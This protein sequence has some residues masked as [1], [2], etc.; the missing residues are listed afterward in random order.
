MWVSERRRRRVPPTENCRLPPT[1]P[2]PIA[3]QVARLKPC[4]FT[5]NPY[6]TQAAGPGAARLPPTRERRDRSAPTRQES[7]S[8]P[9]TPG[10][11]PGESRLQS[12][13]GTHSIR[14]PPLRPQTPGNRFPAS[15][16]ITAGQAFAKGGTACSRTASRPYSFARHVRPRGVNHGPAAAPQYARNRTHTRQIS[17]THT[18]REGTWVEVGGGREEGEKSCP[19]GKRRIHTPDAGALH[20][21]GGRAD[22]PL[23]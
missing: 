2:T 13:P 12:P 19:A 5:P 14:S 22:P 8:T 11:T 7:P 18:Q 17:Q 1:L 6:L 20:V 9:P 23:L 3:P 10:R 15:Q 21:Q 16:R 4:A